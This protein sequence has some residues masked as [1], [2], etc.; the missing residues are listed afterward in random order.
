M[1]YKSNKLSVRYKEKLIIYPDFEI[2]YGD[3]V[4]VRGRSGTG[5]SSLLNILGLIKK[6]YEGSIKFFDREIKDLND[7]ETSEYLSK[8]ICYILQEDDLIEELSVE[9]NIEIGSLVKLSKDELERDLADFGLRG[10]G[11]KKVCELSGGEKR[12]VSLVKTILS[13]KDILILDEPF[14]FLDFS[15]VQKLIDKLLSSN[16]KILIISDIDSNFNFHKLNKIIDLENNVYK[17]ILYNSEINKNI[18]EKNLSKKLNKKKFYFFLLKIKNN[19]KY[20]LALY[21]SIVVLFFLF[22]I[23]FYMYFELVKNYRFFKPINENYIYIS[24]AYD[25]NKEYDHLKKDFE[26][27]IPVYSKAKKILVDSTEAQR[28]LYIFDTSDFFQSN[29]KIFIDR[30][31]KNKYKEIKKIIIDGVEY[32]NFKYVNSGIFQNSIIVDINSFGKIDDMKIKYILI[33]TDNQDLKYLK[34]LE[35]KIKMNLNEFKGLEKNSK[36]YYSIYS[37]KLLLK[38]F[39]S[40]VIIF[41]TFL[42]SFLASLILILSFISNYIFKIVFDKSNLYK[43]IVLGLNLNR[44]IMKNILLMNFLLL[45]FSLI[46]NLTLKIQFH[47]LFMSIIILNLIFYFIQ[48]NYFKNLHVQNE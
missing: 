6:D 29:D 46:I 31:L 44:I 28:N 41:G 30:T 48:K 1:V 9:E 33:K 38:R 8:N 16:S 14:K 24:S 21:F 32:N 45:G 17:Q 12:R 27:V 4:L 15:L 36:G 3:F 47:I 35:E 11:D 22:L 26:K 5:K 18:G 23:S 7:K 43:M 10:Y 19:L 13:G 2:G 20:F 37:G 40:R 34:N 25:L 42:L 39:K